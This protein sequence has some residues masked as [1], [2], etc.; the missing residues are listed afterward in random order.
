MIIVLTGALLLLSTMY[1]LSAAFLAVQGG[2]ALF[3]RR[4]E[5]PVLPDHCPRLAVVIPAHNESLVIR[6]TIDSIRSHFPSGGRLLVVADNCTDGTA[7]VALA[8]GAE[9]TVRT[10]ADRKG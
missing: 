9:V 2:A 5:R 7:E 1:F 8:A 3:P 6:K 10:D 4:R